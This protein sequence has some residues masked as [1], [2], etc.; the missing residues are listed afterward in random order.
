TSAIKT[1]ELNRVR[2]ATTATTDQTNFTAQLQQIADSTTQPF[3]PQAQTQAVCL[4]VRLGKDF[5]PLHLDGL[6]VS[7]LDGVLRAE[8]H[9]HSTKQHTTVFEPNQIRLA[10]QNGIISEGPVGWDDFCPFAKIA[11]LPPS[12]TAGHALY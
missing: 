2:S 11:L 9:R 4:A 10:V 8:F 3:A 7:S 12:S 5:C 6:P 1:R